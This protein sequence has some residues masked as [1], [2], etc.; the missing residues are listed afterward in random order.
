MT[1]RRQAHVGVV[2]FLN[3]LAS[4]DATPGG[5]AAAALTG[6]LAAALVSMV[7]NLTRGRVKFAAAEGEVGDILSQAEGLRGS[8]AAAVEA[9][10]VAFE[11]VMAAYRL[12][13][14]S[15]AERAERRA[16]IRSAA[17]EAASAPLTVAE[18][19]AAIVDLCERAAPITNPNVG[20]DVVVAALLAG[21]AIEAAAVNVEVNLPAIGDER[22]VDHLRL[23]LATV[24]ADRE[25]RVTKIARGVRERQ[26][27]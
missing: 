21:A 5:G 1:D 7:C 3:R 24:R 11:G 9:D 20:S 10:A 4:G 13:R 16:A 19:C 18:S 15:E 12:P 25:A 14:G 22:Y 27:P 17:R 2:E 6:A 23:R 8:L 26:G